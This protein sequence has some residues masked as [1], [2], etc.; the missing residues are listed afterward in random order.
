[1]VSR[2]NTSPETRPLRDPNYPLD[3]TG[4]DTL[5]GIRVFA[6]ELTHNLG[7]WDLYD[8]DQKLNTATYYTP[9]DANDHPLVDWDIMG[10]YGYGYLAIG[11]EIPSHFCGWSKVKLGY[12]EP[13]ELIGEFENLVVYDIE[14]HG[15]SSLYKVPIDPDNGEYFLLEYRNRQA[16]GRFD[17]KDSDF[18]VYFWPELTF[19]NGTWCGNQSTVSALRT[20][21]VLGM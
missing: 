12:M 13:I 10:Y 20:L 3:F 16:T 18:S 5:N 6:H 17:K 1:M 15:D 11:S 4:T 14:T 8:Y 9:D 19:G 7:L 21:K 2:V